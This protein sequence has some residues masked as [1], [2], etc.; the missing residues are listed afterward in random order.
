[1]EGYPLGSLDHNVPLMVAFGLHT[2][3]VKS[4]HDGAS[5]EQGILLRSDV[6]SLDT[7]EAQALDEYFKEVDAAGK[8]WSA[9]ARQEP[10]RFRIKSVGRVCA[11]STADIS[12]FCPVS[13]RC[14]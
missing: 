12:E 1:M 10:Y 14:I 3:T 2:N 8:S 4:P 11:S 5:T 13:K 9:A 6:P 7:R